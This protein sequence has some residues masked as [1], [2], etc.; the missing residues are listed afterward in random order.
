VWVRR[1]PSNRLQ[2]KSSDAHLRRNEHEGAVTLRANLC[3]L[4]F[5]VANKYPGLAVSLYHEVSLSFR[6]FLLR[7]LARHQGNVRQQS[8]G[9]NDR[10][11]HS[12][13]GLHVDPLFQR[14]EV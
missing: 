14:Y 5:A 13:V 10:Y 7:A 8:N 1:L 12:S 4:T 6:V 9:T 2:Q 11:K 3:N